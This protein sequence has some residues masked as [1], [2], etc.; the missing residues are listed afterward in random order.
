MKFTT[1]MQGLMAQSHL[2]PVA[3][4]FAASSAPSSPESYYTSLKIWRNMED[5]SLSSTF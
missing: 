1:R 4:D 2:T 3:L 5:S